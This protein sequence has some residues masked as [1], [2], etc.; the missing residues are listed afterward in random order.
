MDSTP[1]SNSDPFQE[2][3][4][5]MPVPN[6]ASGTLFIRGFLLDVSG[7][8]CEDG[9]GPFRIVYLPGVG[10]NI[11]TVT[12]AGTL[13]RTVQVVVGNASGGAFTQILPSPASMKGRRLTLKKDS[14]GNAV[15]FTTPSGTIQ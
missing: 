7:Q 3:T 1:I 11:Q 6:F 4:L 8:E 14:S 9:D 5:A 10:L 2:M 13:R 15:T 12:G